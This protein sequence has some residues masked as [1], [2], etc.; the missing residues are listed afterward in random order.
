MKLLAIGLLS[1]AAFTLTAFAGP[2]PRDITT[3]KP[4]AEQC[5]A[6]AREGR[7]LLGCAQPGAM[8]P[9]SSNASPTRQPQPPA[10]S[11]RD[12]R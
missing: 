9:A 1:G 3:N 2:A 8:V 12:P 11:P 7:N 5:A 6:A 4:S 10:N